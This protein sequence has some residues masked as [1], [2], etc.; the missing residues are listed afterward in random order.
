MSNDHIPTEEIKRDILDTQREI[1]QMEKDIEAY[2]LLG[3]NLSTFRAVNLRIEI[4]KR[5]VFILQLEG[6]IKERVSQP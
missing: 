2:D 1:D 4:V 5:K 6:L 3:D